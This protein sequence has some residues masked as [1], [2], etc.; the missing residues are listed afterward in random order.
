[1]KASAVLLSLAGSALA[2]PSASVDKRQ[3]AVQVT[4][5]LMFSLTLPQ[6]TT[7]RNNRD[8][9]TLN[10]ETDGCTS[11]PDNPFGFPFV[12]ACHRHDFGYHNFRAQSR[13]TETN[14]LRIDDNFKKDLY[15]Q[16]SGVTLSGVCRGLADVYYAA[17]RAF[18]GGD[19]APGKRRALSWADQEALIKEYEDKVAVYNNLVA[20]AETAGLLDTQPKA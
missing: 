16:C 13:F 15:F 11:S 8:P 7:R 12:P 20:E 14:K 9:P 18:G 5:Q 6:F 2:L 4:D 10:W 1:M 17:V 3:S 19:A